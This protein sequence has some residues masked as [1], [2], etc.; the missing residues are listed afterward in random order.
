MFD[1]LALLKFKIHAAGLVNA[2]CHLDRAYTITEVDFKNSIIENHLFEKWKLVDSMKAASS[3]EDYYNRIMLA[4]ANQQSQGVVAICSF[5]DI[6]KVSEY[7]ALDAALEAKDTAKNRYNVDLLIANQTLKPLKFKENRVLIENVLDD[8]D[9]IGGLPSIDQDKNYHL[10]VI[11][12]WAKSTGKR[13]H[14]HVDQLNSPQEKETELL[15]RKTI[16]HGLEGKV[17]AIHSISLAAHPQS[18]RDRVYELCRDAGISFIS[19]PTAWID[20]RRTETLTP[21]HN[22]V[23]PLDE[24]SAKGIPLAIGTDNIYDIYKPFSNGCMFTELR[25]LLEANHFYNIDQLVRVAT[26][27][28]RHVLGI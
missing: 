13:L 2:H 7:R 16:E 25:V 6:D 21:F 28:G 1:P 12:S 4:V 3:V 5:I 10:D 18:Y 8:I 9:I 24:I 14:V 22:A 20:H 23:T 11:F 26:L 19:C 15:C 17:S 27:D